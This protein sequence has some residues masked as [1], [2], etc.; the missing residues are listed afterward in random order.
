MAAHGHSNTHA[1]VSNVQPQTVP[2]TKAE[3]KMEMFTKQAPVVHTFE[4]VAP[5][6][7]PTALFGENTKALLKDMDALWN[8]ILIPGMPDP[9]ALF[10]TPCSDVESDKE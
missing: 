10:E 9:D 8:S 5:N 4:S 6:I 7:S 2:K 3:K 1:P